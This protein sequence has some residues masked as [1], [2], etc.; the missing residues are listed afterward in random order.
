MLVELSKPNGDRVRTAE[1]MALVA[2]CCRVPRMVCT[3][4]K[5]PHLMDGSL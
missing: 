3:R 2:L 1:L 5:C 4:T